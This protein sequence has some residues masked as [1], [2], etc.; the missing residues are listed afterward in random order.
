MT[1]GPLALRDQ[2]MMFLGASTPALVLG[3][4]A[5]ALG[6]E[7]IRRLSNSNVA[8]VLLASLVLSAAIAS[9]MFT[10]NAIED[11]KYF[12]YGQVSNPRID[13]SLITQTPLVVTIG[14]LVLWLLTACF[15]LLRRRPRRP[16]LWNY[17]LRIVFVLASVIGVT[18]HL[19]VFGEDFFQTSGTGGGSL[20]FLIAGLIIWSCVP[21]Y[22]IGAYLIYGFA[23]FARIQTGRDSRDS[24][25]RFGGASRWI[26]PAL[27]FSALTCA[28]IAWMFTLDSMTAQLFRF[29]HI[30]GGEIPDV[31]MA[32][33]AAITWLMCAAV[34]CAAG[35]WGLRRT[36][37]S[38]ILALLTAGI[39]AFA[40]SF[41]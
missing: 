30:M 26:S 11:A 25:W 1:Y 39:A 4:I 23:V 34:I 20:V 32:P 27:I 7:R 8:L 35:A 41:V 24:R 10:L 22:L 37:R 3:S 36:L 14:L 12:L 31:P 9:P 16:R 6:V 2:R 15:L 38:G 40:I 5:T 19:H 18:I 13:A 21:G 33:A 17:L 29:E 28:T